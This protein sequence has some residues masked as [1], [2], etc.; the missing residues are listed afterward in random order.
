[1]GYTETSDLVGSPCFD[2]PI[3]GQPGVRSLLSGV[4]GGKLFYGEEGRSPMGRLASLL[5][6]RPPVVHLLSPEQPVSDAV[7][8][9]AQH[10]VGVVMLVEQGRLVGIFS[11]R[12]LLR[13]VIARARSPE[14]TPLA[15]VM[16][17]EPV[18]ATRDEHCQ[19]AI[20]KMQA[21][22]CRHLPIVV[23]GVVIDMLSM[24]DLLWVELEERDREIEALRD[25]IHGSY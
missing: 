10:Q 17:P 4:E 21:V 11:E 2:I 24:R 23:N 15:E 1:M 25:Y 3:N 19:S 22:G 6:R 12:D 16:T 14:K 7:T 13:R 18:T 5:Q 20:R 9:M 8:V